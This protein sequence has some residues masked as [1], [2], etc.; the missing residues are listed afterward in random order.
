MAH[1]PFSEIIKSETP[2]LVDFSAEW[3]GPCKM[4]KPIL[5][6]LKGRMGNKVKIVKIDVDRNPAISGSY[7][8]Q[9]V[10][11]LMLFRNGELKWRQSGVVPTDQLRTVIEKHS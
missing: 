2:V 4:L 1:A 9:S 6:E 5:E 8:I 11:T 3:C 7:Q 10:P